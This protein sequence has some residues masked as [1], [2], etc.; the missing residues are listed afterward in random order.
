MIFEDL[1]ENDNLIIVKDYAGNPYLPAYN[2]NGIG[3]L[4]PNQG[5]QLKI[6]YE[7][8]LHYISND[9]EYRLSDIVVTK[10]ILSH[11]VSPVPTDNNMTIIIDES[12]WEMTPEIGA[13]IGVYNKNG[14]LVGA[15][16]Y[17]TPV[18]VITVWGDDFTTDIIDGLNDME[19]MKFKIWD[20]YQE[21][22]FEVST[23]KE[24]SN[25]YVTNQINIAGNINI[26]N[27]FDAVRLFDASPNPSNNTTDI[28]FF[29]PEKGKVNISVYNIIGELIN[30]IANS[31]YDAGKHFIEMNVAKLEAGTYFYKM[32]FGEFY[33]TKQ[34]V[35]L[36]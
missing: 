31:E 11:F 10:N 4:L 21:S 14:L 26:N 18:S 1:T 28:S 36:R 33:K 6:N 12:A 25:E 29:I 30:E 15:S 19:S 24:G 3:N 20:Q 5:Y 13:E 16:I 8:T 17:S 27:K 9:I 35:I 22:N 23:W 32:T 2:F 7:D 34:L